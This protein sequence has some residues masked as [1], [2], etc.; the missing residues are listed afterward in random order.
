MAAEIDLSVASVVGLTAALMGY[1][2]NHG[3]A[4]EMIIP[5]VIVIAAGWRERSTAC[6]SRAWGSRRSRSRSARSG[7]TAAWRT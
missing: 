5:T 2:W 7:S 3:W 4:M 1:L 6:W